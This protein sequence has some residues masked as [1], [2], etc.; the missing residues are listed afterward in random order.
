MY[1]QYGYNGS[2]T[3]ADI[4]WLLFSATGQPGMYLLYKELMTDRERSIF[5]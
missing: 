4:S 3:P 2:L 1:N 5:D